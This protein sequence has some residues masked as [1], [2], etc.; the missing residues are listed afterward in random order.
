MEGIEEKVKSVELVKKENSKGWWTE[1]MGKR[2][3]LKTNLAITQAKKAIT[4]PK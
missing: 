1:K 4:V 2:D 3:Y